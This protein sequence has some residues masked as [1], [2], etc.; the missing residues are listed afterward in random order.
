MSTA[1]K[2][3]DACFSA[4][5]NV[6]YVAAYLDNQLELK[7]RADVHLLGSNESD[8]YEEIIVNPTL[9]K[10]VSQRGSIDCGGCKYVIV[11]YGYFYAFIY[12][13]LNGHVTV[14]FELNTKLDDETQLISEVI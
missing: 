14:S 12:P 5:K 4:S 7:S 8:R 11:R 13:L 9:L 1:A 2:I 6:R 10:L 3:I